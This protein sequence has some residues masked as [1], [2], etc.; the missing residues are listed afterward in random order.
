VY[1]NIA[2]TWTKIGT[3]ID[4]EAAD[5]QSGFSVA[6]SSDGSKVAIGA[7]INGYSAGH[8]RVYKIGGL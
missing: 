6:I 1:Q 2:G 5:D 7:P 4:G 3:D 8:V